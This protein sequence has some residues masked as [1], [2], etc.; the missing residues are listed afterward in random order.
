MKPSDTE[1]SKPSAPKPPTTPQSPGTGD[2]G[3]G[4]GRP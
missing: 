4:T 1:T 2:K 3:T